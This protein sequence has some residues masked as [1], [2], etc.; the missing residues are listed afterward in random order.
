MKPL[1]TLSIVAIALALVGCGGLS[2]SPKM[3]V[4]I[5]GKTNSYAIKDAKMMKL[6]LIHI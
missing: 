3:D 2:S 4:T 1:L 5:G 6:S